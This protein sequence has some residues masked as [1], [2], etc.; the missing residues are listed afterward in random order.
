MA[1][2]ALQAEFGFGLD[3]SG[4]LVTVSLLT[5]SLGGIVFG[6]VA[7]RVGRT[8]AL[9]A[10]I[11]I[12]SFCSLGTAT[13]GSATQ[14][15]VW[16]ALLGL[17][18]GGEWT[19]GAVLVSESWPAAHRGKAIGIM[20]SGWAVGYILAA[21]AAAVII[22]RFGWRCLFA[23]GV[24]PALLVFWILKAVAEPAVWS[25]TRRRS[26]AFLSIA[27]RPEV[28]KNLG[29]ALALSAAVMF[30]YWGL[31]AWIPNYLATPVKGG[32]VGLGLVKSTGWIVPMQLGALIGYLSFGFLSDR[33]GR[34]PVFAA[35]LLGAAVITPCYGMSA[36]SPRTLMILGP[37]LG[38]LGHGYFSV[39]GALLAEMFPTELRATAQGLSF[40]LGR[41]LSALAPLVIGM[42]AGSHGIGPA[43]ALTSAFFLAGA[44]LTCLLR[45]T[46]GKSLDGPAGN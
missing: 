20:Q 25:Q 45:E 39:F 35:F 24:L 34:R 38:F 46:R 37:P 43:L 27:R 22:P 1:I 36:Q 7:D 6:A 15:I 23:V 30:A 17:G 19:A 5:S 3:K 2:P 32:G 9:M 44:L 33:F 11:L 14:L 41:A 16:R 29:L 10:A 12:Y 42:L 26:S 4:L 13:A 40:N 31:F 28:L 18:M 8:R 21:V